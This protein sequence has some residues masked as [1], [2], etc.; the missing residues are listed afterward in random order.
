MTINDK[1]K[2]AMLSK[3]QRAQA[4]L[5]G[6]WNKNVAYNTTLIPHW[7]GETDSF[8]YEREFKTGKEYRLVNA[9]EKSNNIAFDHQTLAKAL[10]EASG[11]TVEP[12]DLPI[13]KLDMSF[14]PEAME[15]SAFGKRW[16]YTMEAQQCCEAESLLEGVVVSPDKRW[17]ALVRDDNLWVRD[18]ASGQERALTSDGCLDYSYA[19]LPSAHGHKSPGV[20]ALWSPDSK[21]LFT[22][23]I[24][25]RHVTHFPMVQYAPR[26]GDLRP[27]A[28]TANREMAIAG[29]DHIEEYR[30]ISIHIETG[31][32]QAADYRQC[33]VFRNAGSFFKDGKGWWS[34]DSR[35]AYFIE[36]ERGDH[37]A[38]LVEFNVFTGATK[39]LIEEETPDTCFK[40]HLDS[41][42]PSLTRPVPGSSELIW[43]SERS[44]WAHLYLYDL[45]TG[46]LKHPI[47]S[48]D[49]LVRDIL[50]YDASNRELLIQTAA[51][52]EGRNPYLRDIC[53]V[54]IDT[55]DLIPIQ[56]TDHEYTVFDVHSEMAANLSMVTDQWGAHGVAPGGRYLVTTRSRADDVP[57]SF[58]LNGQGDCLMELETADISALPAAWQWPETVELN[59]ADNTTNTYGLVF[60]PTD[61]SPDQSYPI[62]DVSWNHEEGCHYLAGSFTNT[63]LGGYFY[64]RAA[65]F[66]ELGF[67]VVYLFG[68]GTAGRERAFSSDCT[69]WLPDSRNQL[70]RINGIRQLA[71]RY[72]YMDLNRVGAGGAFM[73]TTVAVCGLLGYPEFYKVGVS[74][75]AVMDYRLMPAFFGEAFDALSSNQSESCQIHAYASNLKGKLLLMHGMV[76]GS[77]SVGITLRLIDALQQANKNFDMLLLPN[78]AH[79]MSSYAIRRAWDYLVTHLLGLEPPDEFKLTTSVD[80]LLEQMYAER[81]K[82]H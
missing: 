45:T 32:Q 54:N 50:H 10:M 59:S 70:D 2:D 9:A 18:L 21:R 33:H 16:R 6:V 69:P 8:W 27:A 49:W 44:G 39:V 66:A 5:Q 58:L 75:C 24:D 47:T 4:L 20:D 72:P 46:K 30:F 41:H 7:I 53:R 76:D 31:K 28:A 79:S 42:S 37:V 34:H 29:D 67:I 77:C 64:L 81:A 60:R 35:Y 43:Y 12:S 82:G 71:E 80:L 23:Q 15:F 22:F 1:N 25:K 65:A 61:F 56:S 38:R 62:L 14:M 36:L 55:G 73:S 57:V 63:S 51:R 78:D 74:D 17:V 48:G 3:Y 52:V 68:R 40:L 11:E 26:Q 19:T 13:S